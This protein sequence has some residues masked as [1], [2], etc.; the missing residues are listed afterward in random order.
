MKHR[1]ACSGG[2]WARLLALTVVG[3]VVFEMVLPLSWDYAKRV[4]LPFSPPFVALTTWLAVLLLVY[5]V[6]GQSASESANGAGCSGTHRCGWESPLRG[7][8]LQR[9]NNCRLHCDPNPADRLGNTST[10]SRQ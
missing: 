5:V 7:G 2:R 6:S 8:S 9:A 3:A 4:Q 1:L 10:Q